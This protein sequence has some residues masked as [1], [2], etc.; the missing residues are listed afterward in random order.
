MF[1]I[2]WLTKWICNDLHQSY[3]LNS[4]AHNEINITFIYGLE[5]L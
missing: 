4:H 1:D 2:V 5:Q 3:F